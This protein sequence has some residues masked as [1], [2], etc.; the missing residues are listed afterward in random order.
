MRGIGEV[1]AAGYAVPVLDPLGQHHSCGHLILREAARFQRD[2]RGF[3]GGCDLADRNAVHGQ[4]RT[5]RNRNIRKGAFLALAA[6]GDG[7]GHK[8][9]RRQRAAGD[10]VTIEVNGFLRLNRFACSRMLDSVQVHIR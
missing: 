9:M 3:V 2:A 10:G 4:A 5:A 7:Q 8:I 6:V 1:D